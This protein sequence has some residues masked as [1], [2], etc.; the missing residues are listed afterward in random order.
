MNCTA[1]IEEGAFDYLVNLKYLSLQDN[2][3]TSVESYSTINCIWYI[4][5]YD[6]Q[7]FKGKFDSLPLFADF[8]CV[9]F[10]LQ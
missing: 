9:N 4:S 6:Q 1:T 7:F 10:T 2:Q 5:E 3:L 8:E